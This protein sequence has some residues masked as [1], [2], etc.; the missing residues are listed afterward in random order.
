[1]QPQCQ[2]SC[3]RRG[4]SKVAR[5]CICDCGLYFQQLSGSA[6]T[7]LRV[8]VAAQIRFF[9]SFGPIASAALVSSPLVSAGL[10][11]VQ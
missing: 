6:Y 10:F 1:M 3:R 5:L 8:S 11:F 4:A 2:G 7:F 9:F